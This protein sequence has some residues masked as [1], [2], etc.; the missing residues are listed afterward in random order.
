M[1][2]VLLFKFLYILLTNIVYNVHIAWVGDY[3]SLKKFISEDLKL[4]GIWEQ[5][6]VD[7]KTFRTDSISISWRKTKSLLHL[8]GTEAGSI[9]QQLFAKICNNAVT[10]SIYFN[11]DNSN[12][13]PKTI[14]QSSSCKCADVFA[15]I[16]ELRDS[17]NVNNKAVSAISNSVSLIRETI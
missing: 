16:V 9:T 12:S 7:K 14:L 17:Q 13:L 15:N 11:T 10:A 3:D 8:E 2:K 5:P 6:G 1:Y 4:D